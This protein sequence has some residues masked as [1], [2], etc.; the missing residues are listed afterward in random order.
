LIDDVAES[1]VSVYYSGM[2][3]SE[4]NMLNAVYSSWKIGVVA[5]GPS[6]SHMRETVRLVSQSQSTPGFCFSQPSQS[7]ST[8]PTVSLSRKMRYGACTVKITLQPSYHAQPVSP[9]IKTRTYFFIERL[10]SQLVPSRIF[11][12]QP[13]RKVVKK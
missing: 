12:R 9:L 13:A 3:H 6:L 8:E 7:K 10:N 1:A 5:N 11:V 2:V 4:K